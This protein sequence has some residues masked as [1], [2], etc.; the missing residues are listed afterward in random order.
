MNNTVH[1]N[2]LLLHILEWEGVI[3]IGW[4]RWRR[5]GLPRVRHEVVMIEGTAICKVE[6]QGKTGGFLRLL[7][8]REKKMLRQAGIREAIIPEDLPPEVQMGLHPV[9]VS[10]FR[11]A[12]LPQLLEKTFLQKRTESRRV[13]ARLCAEGTSLPVYWAAQ[14]LAQR[15]RYLHLNTGEGQE[16][17]EDWL[18]EKYGLACGGGMPTLEVSFCREA[19]LSALLLGEDCGRQRI[20]YI[21]PSALQEVAVQP[22]ERE[23]LLTVLYRAGKL[24]AEEVF[25]ERIYFCA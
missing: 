14:L 20:D 13:S 6:V 15:V 11:R 22:Q 25:V 4:I 17:L 21:L 5:R 23:Q 19:P 1:N 12:V 3:M 18:R 16:A 2:P 8:R 10:L 9:E 24:R 7:L